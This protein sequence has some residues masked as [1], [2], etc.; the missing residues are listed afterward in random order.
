MLSPR[1]MATASSPMKS[2]PTMNASASPRGVACAAYSNRQPNCVPSPSR[3]RNWS[4][5][6]GVVMTRISRIPAII[7]VDSG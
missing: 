5:S 1:I 3:R 7:S 4:W 6:W 2:A